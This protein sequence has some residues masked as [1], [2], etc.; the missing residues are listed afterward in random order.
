MLFK[1]GIIGNTHQ[2]IKY[3]IIVEHDIINLDILYKIN[4]QDLRAMGIYKIG[5][6]LKIINKLKI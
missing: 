6:P 5:H 3:N 4:A 2:K 1:N